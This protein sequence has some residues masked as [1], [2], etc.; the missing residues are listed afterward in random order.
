[1]NIAIAGIGYVGLSNGVL[2]AQHNRVTALDIVPEKVELLNS[3]KRRLLTKKSKN[4]WRKK[5]YILRLRLTLKK[6]F[7]NRILLLFPRRLTMIRRK[8]F[9]THLR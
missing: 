8:T 5:I 4:I 3:G 2:L 6:R 7:A 9:L 1:M